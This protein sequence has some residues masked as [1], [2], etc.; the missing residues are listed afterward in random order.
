MKLL[1]RVIIADD[2]TRIC[3]LIEHLINWE[4]LGMEIV[5]IAD[6]GI[7]A[8]GLVEKAHPDLVITD[9][10]MPGYDGLEL[11]EK[12]KAINEKL[13]FII[14][15]GYEEFAYA[16]KAI[17]Y[18][19]KDYLCKP[20]NQDSLLKAL[21][22]VKEALKAKT[23]H[24]SLEQEYQSIKKDVGKIRRS[25]LH[26]L[27]LFPEEGFPENT[28]AEINQ[29]YYF[30]FQDGCFRV[31]I[32]KI[33]GQGEAKPSTDE[34]S[35]QLTETLLTALSEVTVETEIVPSNSSIV[36]LINYAPE[37]KA[38]LEAVVVKLLNEYKGRLIP[39]GLMITIGYGTE[40][41][42]LKAITT[43]I[44]AA[45]GAIDDRILKGVGRIIEFS[46]A[47]TGAIFNAD[48][49]YEF[50]RRFTKAVE[51][52]DHTEIKKVING[53]KE[54]LSRQQVSGS[55]IKRLVREVGNTY[56][57]T[58][59]NSQLKIE[60]ATYEQTTLEHAIDN[61]YALDQLFQELTDQITGSLSKLMADKSQK[62]VSQ[63]KQAKMYIEQNY[64]KNITLEDLG[65]YLGFN[66]SYFSSFFKK[67]TGTSFVEYL[68]KVRMEKAK[69]LLKE[70]GLRIQDVCLMVGYNDV[71][72]FT[73]LFI[74][75][76]GLKPNEFRKLFA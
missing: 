41:T 44:T 40:V 31:M 30:H 4:E 50:T 70:Q 29:N 5:G 20:I 59:R 34:I 28:L 64:M 22:R 21:H 72:Y 57:I 19:V 71:K 3:K 69:E 60:D 16:Q 42:E 63:I 24:S 2:E 65:S 52:V 58:M 32:I 74:K 49:Y 43:S 76:T 51:L 56:Y 47:P 25:F 12:A 62:N 17:E 67:E 11:I 15:S 53:L 1:I 10:R 9:I 66:S 33:D 46:Q 55:E 14:I 73:K 13:E 8:L 45:Q 54:D 38:K 35:A 37:E 26:N 68:S 27:L 75:H 6:N 61:C 23:R 18:G 48:R 36:V 7:D 39:F